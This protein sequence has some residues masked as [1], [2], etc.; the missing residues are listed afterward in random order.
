MGGTTSPRAGWRAA[1]LVALGR[2]GSVALAAK[3]AGIDRTSCYATR[4]RHPDFAREW[5]RAKGRAQGRLA[6][7]RTP[8]LAADEIV[9]ASG[10]GRPCVMRAG[11]GRWSTG[12][13]AIF[14]EELATDANVQRAAAAAGVS[15]TA[16]YKRRANWPGFAERWALA[17][18]Q[19]YARLECLLVHAATDT[20]A[21]GAATGGRDT[22]AMS[23]DQA[24][25][26]FRLHRQGVTGAGG[27][28]GARHDRRRAEPSIEEVRAEVL[29]RVK[30][31]GG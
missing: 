22:P 6:A 24:L 7:G 19:G 4:K 29:R 17:L 23:V 18:A 20:L 15:A 8:R 28:P 25:N 16:V 10:S 27:R 13:E 14:L 3:T 21:G 11:P 5:A 12:K 1:F 26:L 30:A 2:S 31:L 9:R